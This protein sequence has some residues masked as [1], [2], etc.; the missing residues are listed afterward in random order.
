[1]SS[2]IERMGAVASYLTVN[3][4]SPNTPGL[5][6]LQAPE[7]LDALLKRVQAARRRASRTSRRFSSSSRPTLPTPICPRWST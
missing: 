1:M 4:S 2:G 6:D 3:I 7:A 5:R